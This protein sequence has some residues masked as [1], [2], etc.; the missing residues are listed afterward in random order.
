M[1]LKK[2]VTATWVWCAMI[3]LRNDGPPVPKQAA[4]M[5]CVRGRMSRIFG[6]TL[7]AFIVSGSGVSAGGFEEPIQSVFAQGASNAGAAAGGSLSTMFWNPATITQSG[8]YAAELDGIGILSKVAQSG[9]ANIL[10]LGSAFGFTSAVSNSVLSALVPSGY[11][12]TQVSDR[13]WA[14]LSFNAPFG[15]S[16]RFSPD[17]AGAFYAQNTT[18]TTYNAAPTLAI[19]LTDWISL[20][21]GLQAQYADASVAFASAI[22][23][24]GSPMLA[25]VAGTG[26][27]WGWTAGVTATL[28]PTTGI[29][30]GYRSAL[31]QKIDATLNIAGG[32]S[33]PGS[34]TTTVKLPDKLSLGLRQGLTR[35]LTLLGTVEWTGWS[36]IGTSYLL[37]LD[38]L[39]RDPTGAPIAIPFQY[40]DGWFYSIGLEYVANPIWTLR[41]GIAFVISPITDQ[42]RTPLVPDDQNT[43][44]SV[45]L[46]GH[47]TKYLSIDLAY[48]Y[49]DFR[50][51]PINVTPGNPSF[52]GFATYVGT[53]SSHYNVL[54]VALKYKFDYPA[55]P[56]IV[57]G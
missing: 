10:P 26:W 4:C 22:I 20:G 15:I 19:K 35:Q 39:A 11:V 16:G 43:W 57:K 44:Y 7:S 5:L 36:R 24:P 51:T 17:W 40:R 37:Q 38:R 6:A 45:G 49:V 52:N 21:A 30:L 25:Q 13:V 2:P 50:S 23:G 47:P 56:L 31:D 9:N 29:G 46:T 41:G 1:L 55:T 42:V 53:A 3:N 34:V 32:L 54:S 27:A 8:R 14:G 28:G 33:T 48:T 18:L 12:S